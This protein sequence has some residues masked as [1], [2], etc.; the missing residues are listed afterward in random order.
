MFFSQKR[1]LGFTLLEMLVV[2]ALIGVLAAVI[3][4]SVN[5]ARAKARD[6]RR[7]ADFHQMQVALG[8]YF[9]LN[10][11]YPRYDSGAVTCTNGW[12]AAN[13]TYQN[14]WDDLQT[15]LT[16][17]MA[18]L[19]LDP[20]SASNPITYAYQYQARNA[21]KGY[22]LVFQPETVSIGTGSSCYTPGWYC[23]GVNF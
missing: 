15:K 7:A 2:I 1:E 22:V 6:A 11:G 8:L 10:D 14:C 16:P 23:L 3:L 13:V 19:P 17:Y 5:S 21:G 9:D 4:I 20:L 18:R 12:A